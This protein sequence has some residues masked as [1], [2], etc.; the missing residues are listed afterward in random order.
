[1]QFK[2]LVSLLAAAFAAPAVLASSSGVVI[3]QVY[4]GGG[5]S[6]AL[7]KQD[8]IEIFNAGSAPVAIGGWSVQYASA[9]GT[10]WALT[11]VPAGVTLQ[12]G[13]YYLFRQ[14]AG[15]TAGAT[16]D[17]DGDT[18]GTLGLSGTTGKVALVRSSTALTGAAPT[19]AEDLIAW[20]PTAT[21]AEGSSP[22]ALLGNTTAH[23]RAANGCTDTDNNAADFAAGTPAP[24]RSTSP[25][26]VCGGG[27]TVNQPIVPIC[28]DA[29]AASGSA[30]SFTVRATDA[31]SRVNAVAA[32]GSLPAGFSLSDF[33]A[34]SADG[35][36]ATVTVNVDASVP[37]G[38]NSLTLKWDNDEA[39]TASCTF[40]VAVS[41]VVSIP[42]IQGAGARSPMDGASVTTG[43]IV[44]HRVSNGFYLQDPLGDGNPATSDGIFVFTSTAPTVAV[45]DRITLSAKV[46]EY[47]ISTSAASQASPLTELDTVTGLSILSSGNQLPQPV[48]VSLLGNTSQADLERY[49]GMLVRV[50]DTLTVTQTNF[51]GERGRLSLAAGGRTLNPTNLLRPGTAAQALQAANLARSLVLD[52]SNSATFPNPTP[53]LFQ[54]GT[55]RAGDTVEGLTGVLDFGPS[56]SSTSGALAYTVQ[57]TVAPVLVRALPRPATPPA[58]GG[59]IRVASANV[60]NF[61]TTFVN[62]QSVPGGSPTCL[63]GCRGANDANEFA[64]QRSKILASLSTLN[65]DVVGLMEIQNNGNFAVQNLVDGL[66]AI[67][68]ANTYAAAPLPAAGTGTDAIRVALIYKPARLGLVGA[69]MSDTNNVNSR[70]TF[71]QGFVA[72]NGEKFAVMVNHLKSKGGCGTGANADQGDLQGCHNQTRRDQ[73]ARLLAWLPTVQAATG[74]PD[75]LL[76][77]DMNAYAKE[78][79]INDLTNGGIVD[80]VSLFDPADYSYVFDANAGRLDHG[81]GTASIAP[82][83]SGATSWHINADEPEW[84]DYNTEDKVAGNDAYQPNAFR[85]SDHDPL[86]IG[87][88]LYKKL[89]G[90]A[91]NDVIVGTDGDDIIEGGLG[92]DTLTGRGGK[93]QFVYRSGA[94]GLDT[95]TDFKPGQDTLVFTDLLRSV[96]ISSTTPLASGHVSCTQQADMALI[97]YDP[98]GSAGP[99]ASRPVVRL[100]GSMCSAI[101]AT[102][103]KF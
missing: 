56:G 39:Q 69:S 95:I 103:F 45:G 76:I 9:A 60:L 90:T 58:V 86:I 75:V 85:S 55:V 14:A 79:P 71:A 97:G 42:A 10:S 92:R 13:Q 50:T 41:G 47:S 70:P 77:G 81:L 21:G 15:T 22:A 48:E 43:G 5:N 31:D 64:R 54:D 38:S 7:L 2:P 17:V 101:D 35:V 94:D 63:T 32:V 4:G 68:G 25:L 3:S 102:S 53:Y 16:V 6:G 34:A 82:K 26:N 12:P 11:A 80:L 84:I 74:T 93:N 57:P 19:G 99:A 61:F 51:V 18:T 46:K 1:M 23:L 96:G 20:G 27:G 78:D 24:R 91:G 89:T 40:R 29:A 83:I 87:I 52:D 36:A 59:N 66:N 8:F 98:D 73:A 72:P 49:E 33:V 62:G 37:A 30:S 28:P 100:K 88:N 65:A 67:L 44:T